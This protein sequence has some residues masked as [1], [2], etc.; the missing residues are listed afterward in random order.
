[1]FDLKMKFEPFDCMSSPARIHHAVH[2][3]AS[4]HYTS[5]T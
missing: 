5:V 1:M 2:D 4:I 3:L